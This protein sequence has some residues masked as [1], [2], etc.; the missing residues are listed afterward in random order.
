MK[1]PAQPAKIPPLVNRLV[2]AHPSIIHPVRRNAING[3]RRRLVETDVR[4]FEISLRAWGYRPDTINRALQTARQYLTWCGACAEQG[5]SSRE[6]SGVETIEGFLAAA[7]GRVRR[8]TQLNYYNDLKLLFRWAVTKGLVK[9]NP[10][11]QIQR[12]RPSMYERERDTSFLPYTRGEFEGLLAACPHWNWLGRRDIALLWVLWET[13]LRAGEIVALTELN[14]DWESHVLAVQRGKNA[15]RYRAVLPLRCVEA[16]DDYLRWRPD[17][18]AGV[19]SLFLD[20][21]RGVMT[22]H[23]LRLMLRNL[24]HRIGFSK[25]VGPHCWRHNFA[26][27]MRQMGASDMRVSSLMGHASPKVTWGYARQVEL[28]DA[29]AWRR[30]TMEGEDG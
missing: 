1:L 24:A 29:L 5:R 21:H 20:R 18:Q 11:E 30:L 14:I 10:V 4:G 13:P 8:V 17:P 12:P 25:P 19:A 3:S 16:I 2:P 26:A 15:V 7:N 6:P 9:T 22:R 28:E 27:R 23:A